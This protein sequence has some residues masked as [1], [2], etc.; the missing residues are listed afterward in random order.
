LDEEELKLLAHI[1]GLTKLGIPPPYEPP[2]GMTQEWADKVAIDIEVKLADIVSQLNGKNITPGARV[3]I[4][5]LKED[6]S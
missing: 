6:E 3:E 1:E 2:L 5:P 4:A